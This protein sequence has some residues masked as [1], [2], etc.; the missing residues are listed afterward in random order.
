[1]AA[2]TWD[3]ERTPAGIRPVIRTTTLGAGSSPRAQAQRR[4]AVYRRRRLAVAALAVT[5]VVVA[6]LSLVGV[7]PLRSAAAT[8]EGH[9]EQVEVV[10]APGDTIW[11]LAHAHAPAGQS[12]QTY[13]TSILDA[14]DLDATA[15]LPGTV[16]RLP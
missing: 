10:I 4:A 15:L 8:V 11:D 6:T 14:N 16:L 9:V 7:W 12:P 3:L 13:I 1:M 2:A 5:V